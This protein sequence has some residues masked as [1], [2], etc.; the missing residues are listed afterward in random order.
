VRLEEVVGKERRGP[1]WCFG[2]VELL[3]VVAP[4]TA[5]SCKDWMFQRA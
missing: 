5:L 1:G 2:E 3:M 4:T